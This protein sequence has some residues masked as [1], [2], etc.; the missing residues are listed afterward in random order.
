[1]AERAHVLPE[2]AQAAPK[3][4]RIAVHGAVQGV[5]FR[6]FVHRLAAEL[7]LAGWVRNSAEGVRIEAEGPGPAL[8]EFR[9]RLERE[10]P[11]E[12][13]GR[14]IEAVFAQ[15]AGY[16]GF[17]IRPPE[18]AGAKT[19]WAPLDLAT[20]AACRAELFDPASRR[21]RYPFTTCCAC[22]PRYT[23]LEALPWARA[24]TAMRR[25]AMCAACR[26][27]Y[28]NPADR[29]FHAE[30]I[31]CPACGPQLALWHP[32]GAVLAQRDEALR[33]A[34]IVALKGL[35][36]FQLLAD[37]RNEA[38]LRTLRA[39][40]RRKA[41]PFA[42]MVASLEAARELCSVDEVE[43]ALLG[44]P[45][46]PIVLLRR[47]RGPPSAPIA[48]SVA[49]GL[50]T[51]GVMLAYTPLHHLLLD[52]LGF[53][54][55]ATSGN[56][57]EEP[58]CTDEREAL[59][60]LRGVADLFLVHDRP[61]ARR[62]DD[63]VAQAVAGAGQVLRA[64]RGYAPFRLALSVG[65]HGHAPA[66]LALGGEL[67]CSV[68]LAVGGEVVA[69]PH[70]G[71]LGSARAVDEFERTAK[72]LAALHEVAPAALACD[73]HPDYASTRYAESLGLAR[74]GV[75]HHHAHVAACML[76]NGLAG[77]VLGVAWDGTGYGADGTIW[78]GEFLRVE[79]A[80]ARRIAWLRPF[81]LPGGE[82]AVREP[83]RAAIGLLWEAFGEAA[84]ARTG[85][86]PLAA[87]DA[88]ERK[89][90]RQMLRAGLASPRCSSVGRLFDAV[91]SLAGLCQRSRYEGEAAIA[92]E[93]AAGEAVAS[94]GYPFALLPEA[95]VGV[96]ID[97][98]P[99]L[100]AVLDDLAADRPPSL[101]A[102]RF[103]VGLAALAEAVCERAGEPDV[104]LTGGC[105]QNR[106]LAE[107]VRARL[108]ARGFRVHL[109]R[110]VPPNDGGLA[111]G[112][113]AVA[114]ARAR[115]G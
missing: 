17:S 61:I 102:A 94:E 71:D 107:A 24:G 105:F 93:H 43:E 113:L 108:R 70:I 25:F 64:A 26:A 27:E 32:A 86:A 111:V 101:V 20:C 16:R 30:T 109:H 46:A 45:A 54:L 15:A 11:G 88:R 106:L 51:L 98:L 115:A 103:H 44:S 53:A 55:V 77:P 78:G 39:R 57:A 114:L 22:G 23:I 79:G 47:R 84:F 36:G 91:A 99:M 95:E 5:G 18:T 90:L 40:K 69:G 65:A 29:R 9:S 89:I 67:K 76:E 60:R 92:L 42:L 72:A 8:E 6:P 75:Q 52:E 87:F 58:I 7:G 37:A 97:W 49:P 19:A 110:R 50:A 12:R 62:A 48:P 3:R 4:L 10:A 63:S 80:E 41:K 104:V 66:V 73:L 1:M 34:A 96:A 112:Q 14:R 21:Y 83:R 82:A 35:G 68:A 13:A 33:Q 100:H 2:A 59:E 74:T 31:A 28:E 85:L 81:P 56:L 38:T